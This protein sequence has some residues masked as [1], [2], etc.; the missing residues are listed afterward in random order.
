MEHIHG[1]YDTDKHF[2][3]DAVTK[4]IHNASNKIKLQQHS[5][6]S[7]RFT[8]EIPRFIE[9][10]DMSLCNK[11][12][13]HY[14]NIKADKT[15]KNK[16]VYKVK[17]MKVL[18]NSDEEDSDEEDV[19]VFSWLIKK[20]ATQYEGSLNFCIHFACIAD[21]GT[22]EYQL[23]TEIYAGI[24]ISETINN[25]ETVAVDYSDVLEEWKK[26]LEELAA[27]GGGLTEIP[28]DSIYTPQIKNGAVTRDKIRDRAVD[29]TKIAYGT[30]AAENLAKKAVTPEKLDREYVE[31]GVY[32]GFTE[33]VDNTIADFYGDNNDGIPM[34][35]WNVPTT[36]E[37]KGKFLRVNENGEWA[38]ET[39]P[40]AE[41]AEF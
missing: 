14:N 17:D 22:I 9:G 26:E 33:Y 29:T 41:G 6:R 21:D 10:H 20:R 31:K 16:D 37:D 32:D 4:V 38:A 34:F 36:A 7:E 8:F 23:P 3:I 40:M 28:D 27:A 2:T 12:E 30:I 1:V 11:I 24:T 18:T 19:V 13:V 15:A 39:V 25:T 35:M 5:H